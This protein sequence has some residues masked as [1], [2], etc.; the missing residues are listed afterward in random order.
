MHT[1]NSHNHENIK[2]SEVYIKHSGQRREGREW[3]LKTSKVKT[4]N[5]QVVVKELNILG[6]QIAA[7]PARNNELQHRVIQPPGR[8]LEPPPHP[9][10]TV[11]IRLRPASQNFL[12]LGRKR[13]GSNVL[14]ESFV[15]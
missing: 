9:P 5:L 2:D 13:G 7:R 10:Y 14:S 4:G 3:V 11:Q 8:C 6:R 1:G 15:S 12:L